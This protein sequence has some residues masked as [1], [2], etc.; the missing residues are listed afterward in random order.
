MSCTPLETEL[1][2][3]RTQRRQQ[4]QAMEYLQGAG[5]QAAQEQ[6]TRIDADIA[7]TE[8]ALELCR[9]QEAQAENPVAQRILGKV[10]QIECHKA[11]REAGHDEPYL[12]IA[13]FDLLNVVNAGVVGVNLP[14]I[15]VVKVGPWSGVDRRESHGA[16]KLPA[17]SRPAFWDL[18]GQ[19]RAIAHP[20]DVILLVACME[21]DG[22][23]PDA[24]RGA[25]RQNLLASR[26]SNT[27][28]A[29]D[30]YVTA[31]ISNMTAAIETARIAGLDPLHLNE[32]DRID[33][34]QQLA[35]TT[36][37]LARLNRIEPVEKTLRFTQR[38]ANGNA[39]NEY[40]V[41]FS[42]TV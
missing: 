39:V 15:N 30:A 17:S 2:Q 33:T 23:S 14:A 8:E 32:D 13:A 22:S 28:L 36:N 24:I 37:D 20:R 40:T 41:T 9:A 7:S 31:M 3:L 6:L 16:S 38:R 4:V 19:A 29:Y 10:T 12:L 34:V 21:N 27:N 5:L 25:V 18:N 42:F 35:L 1:S 26:V 11:R